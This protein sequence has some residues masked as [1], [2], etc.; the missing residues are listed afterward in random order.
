MIQIATLTMEGTA[1]HVSPP[2]KQLF[3]TRNLNLQARAT[4]FSLVPYSLMRPEW[5]QEYIY[6]SAWPCS[7]GPWQSNALFCCTGQARSDFWDVC[8]AGDAAVKR[9]VQMLLSYSFSL[10]IGAGWATLECRSFG[11]S[12]R[13]IG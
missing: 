1:Q 12:N 2:G 5:T 13:C 11:C 9:Q 6:R 8:H 7:G 4:C 3:A 10:S